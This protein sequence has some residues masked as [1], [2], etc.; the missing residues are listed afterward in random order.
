M[1]VQATFTFTDPKIVAIYESATEEEREKMARW[2]E[3]ALWGAMNPSDQTLAD[4]M[5]DLAQEAAANGL[6]P[7]ILES[8]LEDEA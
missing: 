1:S 6:T 7:E 3:I 8:M 2:I 5:D 4:A